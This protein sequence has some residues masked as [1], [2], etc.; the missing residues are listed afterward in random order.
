MPTATTRVVR[1]TIISFIAAA[2]LVWGANA[3]LVGRP[4]NSALGDD[5][6]NTT[7]TLRGHYGW[8]LNTSSLVVDLIKVGDVA[9]A[10]LMRGLFQS[11]K[12]MH[13]AGRKFDR[14][15]LARSGNS[16]Y[17]MTGSDFEELG[18]SFGG[19]Q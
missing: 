9:P 11:A 7:Y 17:L 15:F 2:A 10:D 16:V 3:L 8:Y 19:S 12:A 18:K 14:V 5:P 6:R 13:D 4:I 1:W